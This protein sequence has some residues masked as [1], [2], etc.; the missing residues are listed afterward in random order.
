MT[1]SIELPGRARPKGAALAGGHTFESFQQ[2]DGNL[3]RLPAA[4]FLLGKY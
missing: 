1:T 4:Y 2:L 3:P